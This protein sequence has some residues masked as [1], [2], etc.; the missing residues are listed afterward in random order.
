MYTS[1]SLLADT[2]AV[3]RF[4]SDGIIEITLTLLGTVQPKSAQITFLFTLLP[5]KTGWAGASTIRRITG[6]II[7]TIADTI[8][9]LA[10]VI[11]IA[12]TITFDIFPTWSAEALTRFRSTFGTVFAI[13]TV[14]TILAIITIRTLFLA[15]FAFVAW[16][17]YA[18][19]IGRITFG[20]VF[21]IA[22]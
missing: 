20:I 14:F 21:A 12:G 2:F 13:T 8:A 7:P 17:T 22:I 5:F 11:E 15:G 9:V 1:P 4:A 16:R 10:V 3:S 6:S 18:G 19:A